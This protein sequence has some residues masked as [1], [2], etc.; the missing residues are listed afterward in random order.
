[1]RFLL[2]GVVIGAVFFTV[3]C[4]QWGLVQVFTVRCCQ[5]CRLVQ[6]SLW[7]FV[8]GAVLFRFSV[9]TVRCCHWCRL[10]PVFSHCEVLSLV[11]SCFGFQ[12]L[13]G[14]VTGSV[15]FRFSV[16]VRCCHWCRLVSVFSHCEVL[17]LV[18]SCS[19]FQSLWGV[20]TGA[21]LFRFSVTVRCCHWCRLVAVFSHC[22]VMSLLSSCFG[23]Q[24]LWGDVTAVVLFRFSVIERC[25]RWCRLSCSGFTF[26][27]PS[28]Q[29]TLNSQTLVTWTKSFKCPD[30]PG[31]D[32]VK[33]L[34]EALQRNAPVSKVVSV[35]ERISLSFFMYCDAWKR[36]LVK[37]NPKQNSMRVR[38]E[39]D[40][41]TRSR[42]SSTGIDDAIV[43]TLSE[44]FLRQSSK[45]WVQQFSRNKHVWTPLP[46]PKKNTTT[47][48]HNTTPPKK[49]TL[50]NN[51]KQKQERKKNNNKKTT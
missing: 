40:S 14:V 32:P 51:K 41:T 47:T 1:M 30:G 2:W 43:G 24:S 6:A 45:F 46:P 12:S 10:V 31:L 27:F 15:L 4:C 26:S 18:L 17:S 13:W 23:F 9:T 29:K 8:T 44:I 50:N 11:P 37:S 22:E 35:A 49:H 16:T 20:V 3:R 38:V 25:C 7:S 19:G 36:T 39:Q 34:E 28:R 48:T 21:V 5:W 42:A 33:L